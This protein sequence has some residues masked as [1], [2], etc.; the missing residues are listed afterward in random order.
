V[1]T[2]KTLLPPPYQTIED[3]NGFAIAGATVTFLDTGTAVL[4][5]VYADADGLVISANPLT[6]DA[7]GRFTVFLS[8]GQVV[9]VQYRDAAGT[10]IKTV[11][12]VSAV[13]AASGNVDVSGVVGEA[14][15]V[16]Q[17]VY[18]SSGFGGKTAGRWWLATYAQAD[19]TVRMVGLALVAGGIGATVTIRTAGQMAGLSG[20]VV[21]ANYYLGPTP[22]VLSLALPTTNGYR[23]V[24]QAD[25]TT[26]LVLATNPPDPRDTVEYFGVAIPVVVP[27]FVPGGPGRSV[28]IKT[29]SNTVVQGIKAGYHGQRIRFISTTAA[30]IDFPHN[31]PAAAAADRLYNFVA[32]AP[33]SLTNNGVIEYE[34]DVTIPG[35]KAIFH[36]QGAWITPPFNAADYV[37]GGA[38]SFTV[39]SGGITRCAYYLRGRELLFQLHLTGTLGGSASADIRRAIPAGYQALGTCSGT[40]AGIVGGATPVNGVWLTT[41]TQIVH[42]RDLNGNNNYPLGSVAVA[43]TTVIDIS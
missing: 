5:T 27:Q 36:E 1:A 6:V 25:T 22:G 34:Y 23:L 18:L 8:P 4:S 33:T 32:S 20:L 42:Y 12:G 9:D 10:L 29:P 26:S 7:A 11:P 17:A 38:M 31:S 40:W 35:W 43:Q 21:G 14:V 16:G 37:A 24:G 3:L 41:A 28:I 13:P 30:Q 15:T 39:A 19:A 2:N